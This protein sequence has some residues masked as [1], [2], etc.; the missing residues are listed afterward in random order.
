MRAVM[1]GLP[2]LALVCGVPGMTVSRTIS[3]KPDELKQYFGQA[4]F[5]DGRV[6]I[7]STGSHSDESEEE[8]IKLFWKVD[9]DLPVIREHAR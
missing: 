4:S 1:I 6:V 2:V 7:K 3:W 5:K 9:L 8:S